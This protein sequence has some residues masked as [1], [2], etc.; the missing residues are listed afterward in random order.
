M[1]KIID[2]RND[3]RRTTATSRRIADRRNISYPFGSSEWQEHIKN[4][5][6]AWPKS[7]RRQFNRRNVGRREFERRHQQ[8]AEQYSKEKYAHVFLTQGERKLIEDLY[9]CDFE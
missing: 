2:L 1:V 7:E 6:L 4:N 5:Y 9:L 3:A 8:F